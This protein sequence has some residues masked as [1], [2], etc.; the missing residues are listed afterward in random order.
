MEVNIPFH[1]EYEWQSIVSY[2]VLGG[3]MCEPVGWC[4][5]YLRDLISRLQANPSRGASGSHLRNAREQK[6]N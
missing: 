2:Y 4:V 5:T 1:G 6:H 3:S